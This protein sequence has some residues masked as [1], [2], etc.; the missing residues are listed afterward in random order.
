[1]TV[2][3][4]E[5]LMGEKEE[6]GDREGYDFQLQCGHAPHL[7]P[8]TSCYI[9]IRSPCCICV[10]FTVRLLKNYFSEKSVNKS[11]Q[12][13]MYTLTTTCCKPMTAPYGTD[14]MV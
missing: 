11:L 8:K 14:E 6:E 1:M 9:V 4:R 13:L 12:V 7:N 3:V 2:S 10:H 5:M